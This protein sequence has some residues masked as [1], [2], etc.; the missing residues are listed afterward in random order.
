MN[1]KKPLAATACILIF[2]IATYLSYQLIADELA[3]IQRGVSTEGVV[4]EKRVETLS[5]IHI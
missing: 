5:L 1:L 2:A 4:L 3:Y